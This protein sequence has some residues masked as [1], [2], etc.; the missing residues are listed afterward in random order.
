[1]I[2]RTLVHE[3]GMKFPVFRDAEISGR[4][5][6]EMATSACMAFPHETAHDHEYWELGGCDDASPYEET[7][8]AIAQLKKVLAEAEA[9]LASLETHAHEWNDYEYCR[10]CGADGRA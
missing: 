8:A 2:I 10:V 1:M 5:W 6:L 7:K 9:E 4:Q 3:P